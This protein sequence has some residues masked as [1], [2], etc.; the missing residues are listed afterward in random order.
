MKRILTLFIAFFLFTVNCAFALTDAQIKKI[1]IKQSRNEYP[2]NCACPYDYKSN[3]YSCGG[4]SAWSRD[5]GYAPLC[6]SSD[7]T[8]QMV[9]NYRK[10]HKK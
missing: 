3:G 1:L 8:Q 10:T 5:G 7:V 4:T 9:N 2:G 6:Y